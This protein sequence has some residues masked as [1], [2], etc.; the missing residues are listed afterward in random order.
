MLLQQWHGYNAC[1]GIWGALGLCRQLKVCAIRVSSCCC[2]VGVWFLSRCCDVCVL[3]WQ[4]VCR[5]LPRFHCGLVERVCNVLSCTGCVH[6]W[7]LLAA[8]AGAQATAWHPLDLH[9]LGCARLRLRL[10]L[11]MRVVLHNQQCYF[12]KRSASTHTGAAPA[13]GR[14]VV[15]LQACQTAASALDWTVCRVYV[16][17]TQVGILVSRLRYA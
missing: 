2:D 17:M 4:A 8:S 10:C 15:T 6:R 1:K 7:Q 13:V 12:A 9:M 5:S 16:T 11:W 14:H 3:V